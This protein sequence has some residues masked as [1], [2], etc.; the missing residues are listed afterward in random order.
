MPTGRKNAYAWVNSF[1]C[2][3]SPADGYQ[4]GDAS[5]DDTF[6]HLSIFVQRLVREDEQT[7]LAWT[8]IQDEVI[9]QIASEIQQTANGPQQQ[10][11]I[12]PLSPGG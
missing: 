12:T 11:A 4:L 7:L 9:Y 5:T 2:C 3:C 10:M 1:I 6:T 8:P